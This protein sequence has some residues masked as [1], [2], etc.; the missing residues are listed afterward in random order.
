MKPKPK[1]TTGV[2]TMAPIG[3]LTYLIAHS[4]AF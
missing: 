3:L 1:Q 2:P 4:E